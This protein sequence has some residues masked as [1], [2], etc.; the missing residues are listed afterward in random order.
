MQKVSLK[1]WAFINA[2]GAVSY[3]ALLATFL[4]GINKIFV[5]EDDH[6]LAPI[7]FLLLFILSALITGLLVLGRP[8]Y[9]F[10]DGQKKESL[11]LIL[12]T[13]GWLFFFL[14][15]SFLLMFLRQ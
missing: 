12:G 3:V 6:F 14:F 4:Q 8:I 13:A 1:M 10:L 5:K 9:L 2:L 7:A 11:R 15:W